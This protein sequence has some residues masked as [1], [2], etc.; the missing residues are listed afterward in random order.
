[1]YG[2]TASTS[3]LC[4]DRPS[5]SVRHI[6]TLN[7]TP[8]HHNH[9]HRSVS[10]TRRKHKINNMCDDDGHLANNNYH[11]YH[12]AVNMNNSRNVVYEE[13]ASPHVYD[14][15]ERDVSVVQIE[16]S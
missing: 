5:R 11:L 10:S 13:I 4:I 6:N 14:R 2:N 9:H 12:Q 7:H 1:M 3:Q 8:N 16:C 15:R